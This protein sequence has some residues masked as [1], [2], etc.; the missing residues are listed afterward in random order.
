MDPWLHYEL[1]ILKSA[2]A[3]R[4]LHLK[5]VK[6]LFDAIGELLLVSFLSLPPLPFKK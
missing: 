3:K 4:C 2:D 5:L 6:K 1:C